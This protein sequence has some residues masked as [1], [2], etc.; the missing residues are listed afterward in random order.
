MAGDDFSRGAEAEASSLR[1]PSR[2]WFIGGLGLYVA[3]H[4]ACHVLDFR[5]YYQDVG[6]FLRKALDLVDLGKA[7]LSGSPALYQ[8]GLN[9]GPFGNYLAALPLLVSR[10]IE[11]QYY[12]VSLLQI[13]AVIIFFFACR[14]LMP[15]GVGKWC[16]AAAFAVQG[17]MLPHAVDH[18]Y[19]LGFFLAVY[20]YLLIASRRPG[21]RVLPLV[22]LVI[23][24]CLQCHASSF[25]LIFTTLIVIRPWE[26][27]A[28]R[29]QTLL[30]FALLLLSHATMC[31]EFFALRGTPD[32]P[33]HFSLWS[34]L[35]Q[36]Y[37]PMLGA[38]LVLT[39]FSAG[40]AGVIYSLFFVG[41]WVRRPAAFAEYRPFVGGGLF[42]LAAAFVIMPIFLAI[43]GYYD[44]N[45]FLASSPF[46]SV[47]VGLFFQSRD[48]EPAAR[49]GWRRGSLHTKIFAL[50]AV[51]SLA[52]QVIYCAV[53][54]LRSRLE[55]N[56]LVAARLAR[57]MESGDLR[58]FAV[59]KATYFRDARGAFLA[60]TDT[61]SI[62]TL[63]IYRDPN[64]RRR[65][66]APGDHQLA[67]AETYDYA[68]PRFATNWLCAHLPDLIGA[69]GPAEVAEPQLR[70][71]AAPPPAAAILDRF[72][73][74][75]LNVEIRRYD[76]SAN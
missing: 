42:Q 62:T 75:C 74:G 17:F 7:P 23:G 54:S 36:R 69:P 38:T 12:F 29:R 21:S 22:W 66:T 56:V 70:Y 35:A 26:T 25:L 8:I 41:A 16:A 15:Q 44:Y 5:L 34:A 53:F 32:A 71:L 10:H 46:V 50:L 48:W 60:E 27:R 24:L 40:I 13:S 39:F 33:S 51:A 49:F 11:L 68:N 58:D 37:F 76:R 14:R 43:K 31:Y 18:S 59:I 73:A 52:V 72:A 30:G 28:L 20:F 19:Y 3:A 9:L 57:A 65:L 1:L 55:D 2:W 63:A 67:V 4:L 64:L 47:F 6:G 45:Y 61:L